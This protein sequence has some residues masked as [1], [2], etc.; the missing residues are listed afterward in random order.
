MSCL[1]HS[2][3]FT[4]LFDRMDRS[5]D[6]DVSTYWHIERPNGAEA[7]RL[8]E[9][10][11]RQKNWKRWGPYLAERQWGTVR[12]DYSATGDCWDYLPHDHARSRAYRWGEDGLLGI[13]D[14][15]CRLCFALALW[16]GRDPILKER[17]FGLTNNEGNHG[18]D[19]KELYYYL[20]ATPTHSYLKSLYKY[21]QAEFPYNRLVTE[22]GRRSRLEPEFELA[23]TGIFD[24]NRYFDVLAEYAKQSPDDIYIRVTVSNRGPEP[25][26]LQLLPTVWFRN[27]WSWGSAH[28]G[29]TAKP[30]ITREKDNRLLLE[31]ESLKRWFFEIGPDGK[32][33][34]PEVLFTENETNYARLFGI[35]GGNPFVKDA[36]HEFLVKGRKDAVNPQGVGTKAAAVYVL[37]LKPGESQTVC[38]R[39]C[40]ADSPPANPDAAAFDRLFTL[41]KREADE[42]YTTNGSAKL[43]DVERNIVRQGYAGLLWNKQFYHYIVED[44]LDGDAGQPTPP[45]AVSTPAMPTG[46]TFTAAM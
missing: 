22:N 10:G 11:S 23:D 35:G 25:A 13:T 3:G 27:T 32:G 17:L 31:H 20:D 42:F 26:T 16:N 46:R 36:F 41:R 40:S 38:L 14:R 5:T 45:K 15:E 6:T 12:E 33:R 37:E 4:V 18:E 39:L 28:E 9:D 43:T 21:P 8:A 29:C 30:R 24:G 19:V 1:W 34:T 44:W 7:Q 2:T